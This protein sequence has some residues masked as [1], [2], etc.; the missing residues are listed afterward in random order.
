MPNILGTKN[1]LEL[2]IK[3]Q[4]EG[5]LYFSSGEVYGKLPDGQILD[6]NHFGS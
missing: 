2:A 5:Y 1:T 3:N 6:E 4:V